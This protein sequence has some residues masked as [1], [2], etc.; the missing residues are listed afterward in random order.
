MIRP[1]CVRIAAIGS[2]LCAVAGGHQAHAAPPIARG[3]L[4]AISI[5]S[6]ALGSP[7]KAMVYLP[8]GYNAPANR[9]RHYPVLYLLSGAPGSQKD[10]FRHG[11]V[12]QAADALIA[13]H[14]IGPLILVSPD[15]NGGAY[16][17]TQF[18]DSADGRV[19]VE[20][21]L[22]RDAVGYMDSHYRTIRSAGARGLLGYSA[23]AFGAL[24]VGLHHPDRFGVLA[25]FCGYYSA[26]PAEVTR[27]EINHPLG[28]D[29][30]FLRRNSP[31]ITITGLRRTDRPYIFLFESTIDRRYTQSTR[32]F[33]A[34][35]TRLG[36]PHTTQIDPPPA[37]AD[38][39]SWPHSWTYVRFTLRTYMVAI[40]HILYQGA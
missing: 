28:T 18:V 29:P 11:G 6:P 23:G 39:R 20:T 33:D 24:N 21:F 26:D 2:L 37:T 1:L 30:A 27:P 15:G 35:L 38:R 17:D 5:P 36:V 31:S 34:E 8:P 19:P 12:A 3:T 4:T 22:A 7:R 14:R 13:A 9:G 40:D 16:R 25:G 10:W 32:G